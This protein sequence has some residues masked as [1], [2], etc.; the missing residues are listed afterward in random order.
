MIY[1]LKISTKL[2]DNNHQFLLAAPFIGLHFLREKFFLLTPVDQK[3]K[4]GDK[5]D[6]L[7]NIEDQHS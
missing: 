6:I 4:K 3:L 1:A 2:K 5:G 7:L